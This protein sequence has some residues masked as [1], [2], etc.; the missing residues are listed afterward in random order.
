MN[1]WM[2]EGGRDG[3][4]DDGEMDEWMD[5]DGEMKPLDDEVM[6]EW[7]VERWMMNDEE[8]RDG[9]GIMDRWMIKG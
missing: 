7:M 8:M 5:D 6:D 4:M 3:L 2:M 9:T 1:V